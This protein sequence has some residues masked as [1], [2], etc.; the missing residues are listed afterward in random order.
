MPDSVQSEI[1][2]FV[3]ENFMFGQGAQ[4]KDSESLLEAGLIDSTGVLELVGFLES[5]FAIAVADEDLV[6]AN[7]DSV[8]RAARYV[9]RKLQ[10]QQSRAIG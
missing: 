8:E 1:R 9:E 7:L 3:I 6:P 2:S 5:K 10:G 4:L